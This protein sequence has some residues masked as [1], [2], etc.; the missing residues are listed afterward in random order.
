MRFQT[1]N[2]TNIGVFAGE[3]TLDLSTTTA[4]QPIILI[5]GLNGCGKTTLLEAILL[6]FYGKLSP[7][8]RQ[9][10]HS[11][12]EY[13]SRLATAGGEDNSSVELSFRHRDEHGDRLYCIARS[14]SITGT[15]VREELIVSVDGCH[16][17]LLSGH[18]ADSVDRFLPLRLA[19]LFFFDGERIESLADPSMAPGLISSAIDSLL[20][21]DMVTQLDADLSLLERRRRRSLKPPADQVRIDE[22]TK[23]LESLKIKRQEIKQRQAALTDPILRSRNQL[24]AAEERLRERGGDLANARA[25]YTTE[26][27]SIEAHIDSIQTQMRT[28]A[29]GPLPLVLAQGT[30]VQLLTVAQSQL[31]ATDNLRI[32]ELLDAR[33]AVILDRLSVSGLDANAIKT[34]QKTLDA[35]R[36]DRNE[37]ATFEGPDLNL[38]SDTVQ[39]IRDVIHSQL[40]DAVESARSLIGKFEIL[41]ERQVELQRLLGA[42]PDE[43]SLLPLVEAIREVQS[44]IARQEVEHRKASSELEVVESRIAGVDRDLERLLRDSKLGSVAEDDT[45]RF[46]EHAERARATLTEFRVQLI[47]QHLGRL[48]ALILDG[49]QSLLRKECLVAAISIDPETCDLTLSKTDGTIVATERLSAAER[50]LLATAILWAFARAAGRPLPVIIDTPLGRQDS[51]HRANFVDTYLPDAS[52]Q[53][54][55][56]STD[57]EIDDTYYELIKSRVA[58]EYL[59][60]HDDATGCTHIRKG[61]FSMETT[62]VA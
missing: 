21:V 43:D 50:Q 36:A 23:E 44:E 55:V 56:L 10:G 9:S 60:E 4:K 3:Q 51:T 17:P 7:A 53:V 61:Y 13:L 34:I 35:D 29:S 14:W 38:T 28:L 22:H 45:R 18:W 24:E 31:M 30:L 6:A 19:G 2:L 57:E 12:D 27:A 15:R 33:D 41:M 39:Q 46:I 11:Y 26:L 52:H 25:E 42:A 54:L 47:K 32:A 62:D 48:E 5:G 1:L 37:S 16:D 40:A 49:Y 8:V 20:G 59:L 58:T